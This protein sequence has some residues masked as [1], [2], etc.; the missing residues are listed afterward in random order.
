NAA[1][2]A[3]HWLIYGE[4]NAATDTYF[5][6][7]LAGLQASGALTRCDRVFSRDQPQRRYVQDVLLEQGI[8]VRA[9]LDRGAAI[10]VCGS[11]EGMAGGVDNALRE[12]IGEEG[13]RAL[14]QAGR[15]RR[16]V[17]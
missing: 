7:E 13:V 2:G 10:Y 14:A 5:V 6:S 11:L 15:Y 12:L 8:Q 3:P 17:Y 9:W 16:D 4:R 1:S